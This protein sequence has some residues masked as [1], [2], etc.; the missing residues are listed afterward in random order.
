MLQKL[1]NVYLGILRTVVIIASGILLLA[2]IMF[3]LGALKG[4]GNGPSDKPNAPNVKS[5]E[6]IN[7]ITSKNQPSNT[8]SAP[9]EA[10]VAE[11]NVDKNKTYYDSASKKIF[12]FVNRVSKG[13]EN[14]DQTQVAAIIK[15]RAESYN[16]EELTSAYAKGFS[17]SIEKILSDKGVEN[18]ASQTSAIDVVNIVLNS[19]TEEF[20]SQ[21]QAEH[22][23]I[24]TEQQ[25]HLQAK[26]ESA[27]NLYIAAGCFGLFLLIVF[28]SIFIKIERNLRHIETRT[29]PA[30]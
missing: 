6:I 20:N 12:E 2:V 1:E 5:E 17:E 23:R 15:D 27:S 14:P 19:F 24:Q 4:F 26:A 25:E 11:E 10:P 30:A 22:E 8:T 18:K 9:D 13:M 3:G 7:K 28:L 16:S 21:I 29:Q